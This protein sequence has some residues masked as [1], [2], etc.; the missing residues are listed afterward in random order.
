MSQDLRLDPATVDS[1]E[2]VH[3]C[4]VA[5]GAERCRN[6]WDLCRWLVRADELRLERC[7]GYASL[8]EYADRVLGLG[9]RGLEDRLRVGR[10]LRDLPRLSEALR[11]GE[12]VYSSVRELCRVATEQTERE[13]LDESE[14]KTSGQVRAMVAGHERGDLPGD[15]PKPELS[16]R[17]LILDVT[18]EVHALWA[19]AG[20]RATQR[21]GGHL[22]D[23]ALVEQLAT[24]YL[25]GGGER[26]A[27][28]PNFQIALSVG[29]DGRARMRAGGEQVEVD[30]TT[31][32][33]AR[34]DATMIGVVDGPGV[35]ER[36]S[37]TIPPR[38]RRQVIARHGGVCAVPGCTNTICDLHHAKGRADGG[39]HHPDNLCPLCFPHHRAAHRG[40]LLVVGRFSEGLRFLHADGRPYGAPAT[41]LGARRVLAEAFEAL[42]GMGW[43]EREAKTLVDALRCDVDGASPT[44]DLEEVVR[45]ALRRAAV[46]GV[47]EELAP[48]RRVA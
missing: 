10:A 47:R 4:L 33:M 37:Q 3:R 14:G 1:P 11:D 42:K 36:A 5:L 20:A 27:G 46:P 21:A 8:R 26:D 35:A 18:P 2:T 22:D 48:Y 34:C 25:L 15:P 39:T 38:I 7:L 45:E 13:W 12:R 28:T 40:A 32:E 31:L 44:P 9:P 43:K 23:S 6:D 16:M 17:R 24:S 19:E 30:A 29:P 41:D